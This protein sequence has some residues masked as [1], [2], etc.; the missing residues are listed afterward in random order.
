MVHKAMPASQNAQCGKCE[1]KYGTAP[2]SPNRMAPPSD[3]PPRPKVRL[4]NA[5]TLP[6]CTGVRP[7]CA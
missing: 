3:M 5:T 2:G 1:P 4:Q 6:I 7:Q